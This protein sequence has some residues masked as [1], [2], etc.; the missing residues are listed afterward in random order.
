M[1]TLQCGNHGGVLSVTDSSPALKRLPPFGCRYLEI[2]ANGIRSRTEEKQTGIGGVCEILNSYG[3]EKL[4]APAETVPDGLEYILHT[5]PSF[6][7]K[8]A[9][10]LTHPA[11][12]LRWHDAEWL[13]QFCDIQI[14]ISEYLG[15]HPPASSK[16]TPVP[17]ARSR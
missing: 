5:D 6:P 3:I 1:Y 13:Q 7:Q 14:A 2:P 16:F 12:D 15:G 9:D 17:T 10:G 4:Y 8:G 11:A